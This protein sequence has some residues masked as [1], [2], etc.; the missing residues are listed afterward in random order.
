MKSN[1]NCNG[2]WDCKYVIG[3]TY[4]TLI[5]KAMHLELG[6]VLKETAREKDLKRLKRAGKAV[7]EPAKKRRKCLKY[8][9]L[10]GMRLRKRQGAAY[11]AGPF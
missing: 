8:S 10:K 11:S 3:A 7:G 4:H 2:L 6:A 9:H 1:A 5:C